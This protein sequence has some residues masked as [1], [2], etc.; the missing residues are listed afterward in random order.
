[1]KYFLTIILIFTINFSYADEFDGNILSN[2]WTSFG[3][4]SVQNGFCNLISNSDTQ[5][6]GIKQTITDDFDIMA[7]I[8]GDG[9]IPEIE[10]GNVFIQLQAKINNSNKIDIYQNINPPIG[11][12]NNEH[13][14]VHFIVSSPWGG[15]VETPAT[16]FACYRIKRF[17]NIFY[18]YYNSSD[19]CSGNWTEIAGTYRLESSLPIELNIRGRGHETWKIDFVRNTNII[20]PIIRPAPVTGLHIL[21]LFE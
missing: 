1:M 14:V 7:R 8:G 9:N 20:N 21:L 16:Q 3:N 13:K 4:V 15:I 5:W 17:Q 12:L 11:D 10:I 2:N 18:A 19:N 6:T